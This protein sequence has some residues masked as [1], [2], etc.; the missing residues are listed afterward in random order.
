MAENTSIAVLS[1][2][3]EEAW[4]AFSRRI[5]SVQGETVVVVSAADISFIPSPEER[6]SFLQDIEKVRYRVKL[7]TR[8]TSMAAAAKEMGITVISTTKALKE[9]L[10]GHKELQKTIRIF[11]PHLWRRQWR[12]HLQHI[13][14]LSLPKLRIWILGGF[15]LLL[16]FFVVF[17]LLPSAEVEVIPRQETIDYTTNIVLSISGAV[18]EAPSHVRSLELVP[19]RISI[20]RSLVFDQISEEFIG[21]NAK[22]T[23]EIRNSSDEE[24]S[25]R[26][27]TRASNQAGM[28]F[29]LQNSVTIPAGG[30]V[31]VAATAAS[32]DLYGKTIGERGNI[33]AGVRFDF[34]G[35][36]DDERKL[37]YAT[38]TAAATGGR[39]ASR[40]VLQAKDL[41]LASEM[42][43]TK[44]QAE[45]QSMAEEQR[46]AWNQANPTQTLEF[47]RKNDVVKKTFSGFVLPVGDIGKPVTSITIEGSYEY[48]AYAY[49]VTAVLNLVKK[50]ILSHTVEGKHV[51]LD[52]LVADRLRVYIIDY[53][54]NFAWIKIT[55]D[56]LGLQE[57]ALDPLTPAGARFARKVRESVAGLDKREAERILRNFPEVERVKVKMWPPWGGKLPDIPSHISVVFP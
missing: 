33:P 45:A 18:V 35:L 40:R 8:D 54:D 48:I 28:I 24:Y 1:R 42:L 11:S 34:P 29:L 51:L 12:T 50:D 13:G 5:A 6:T 15:S 49:D 39:T 9:A 55:A 25:L 46:E 47:L 16:F 26:K 17:R 2:K 23:L 44:L 10:R 52:S 41:Q 53:D 22:T 27:G 31:S 21:T 14:L 7:A 56:M 32:E 57:F 37:V 3:E 38:N 30:T 43:K 19:F 20:R 4:S 36:T